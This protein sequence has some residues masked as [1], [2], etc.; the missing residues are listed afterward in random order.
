MIPKV[1][2]S[3]NSA[4]LLP[5]TCPMFYQFR[6]V[7]QSCLTLCDPID[8]SM[9]GF[10]VHHQLPGSLLKLMSIKPVMPSNHLILCCPHL[11]LPPSV[12]LSIRVFSNESVL[13]IRY[14]KYWSFSFIISPC[15]EYFGL[16]CFRIDWFDLLIVQ[17]TLK[18]FPTP[19]F[20]SINSLFSLVY[21]PTLTSIHD[22]WKKQSF[23]YMD[24]IALT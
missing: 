19:Q 1:V 7:A 11:L 2:S 22:Y 24:I 10:P 6:S 18:S 12:F 20:Q 23:D 15:N 4:A 17:R 5:K 8:C 16:I 13:R 9:P 14:P 21:G 3:S